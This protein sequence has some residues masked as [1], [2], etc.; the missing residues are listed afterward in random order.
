VQIKRDAFSRRVKL[1]VITC[2][3][4]EIDRFKSWMETEKVPPAHQLIKR[5]VQDKQKQ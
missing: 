4:F 5:H 1:E 3:A 2:Y